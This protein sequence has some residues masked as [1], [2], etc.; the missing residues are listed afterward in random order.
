M[1]ILVVGS[2]AYDNL[3]TPAGR[4]ENV[5][6]GAATHFSTAASFFTTVHIVGVV[7]GD[8]EREHIDFLESRGI[9]LTGLK[10]VADGKTFRW[11]GHYLKDINQAETLAT[12]LG[13]FAKFDP[14]LTDHHRRRPLLFLANIHP[15]LQLKVL[16]QME[17]PRLIAM[18]TMNLW[19]DTEREALMKVIRCADMIFVN[20]AEARSLTGEN[21]VTVAARKIM[22]WGPKYVVVKRGEYGALV[23]SGEK[24]FSVPALPLE[25]VVDPTGA[26]D[27]FA[28]GFLG[29][30]ARVGSFDEMAMRRAAVC[31]SVMASFQVEDFGLERLKRLTHDEI[32]ARFREFCELAHFGAAPI[33]VEKP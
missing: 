19:I 9:N 14:E 33:F 20:D 17:G 18:D 29:Y 8:F 32:D 31:G 4:R 2:V 11:D 15:V 21:N 7:G 27:T 22:E 16:E 3:E 13:V 6:G 1:S 10:V 26:G 28:G 25:E 24:V 23:Y 30:L 5:L 12:E